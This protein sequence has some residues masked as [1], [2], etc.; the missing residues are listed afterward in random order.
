MYNIMLYFLYT[1]LYNGGLINEQ[2]RKVYETIKQTWVFF[3][4]QLLY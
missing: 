4:K 3:S 1:K 2:K